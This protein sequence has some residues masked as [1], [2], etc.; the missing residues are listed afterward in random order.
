MARFPRREAEVAALASQIVNGLTEEAEVFTTPPISIEQLQTSLDN[1]RR[2]QEAA[3]IAQASAAEAFDAKDEA[4]ETLKSEMQLVLSYAEHVVGSDPVKLGALGWG[5][6]SEPSAPQPPGPARALE[7]KREG[8][9]WLY[10]DWKKPSEGGPVGGYHVQVAQRETG[11]W[12]QVVMCF[13]TMAVLTDQDTG[14]ELYYR[15]VTF[16]KVGEGFA[17]NVVAAVL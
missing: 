16:N 5:V 2:L 13:D 8:P 6:R 7:I 3:V 11:N 4:F 1:Y 10:L 12:T 9:G 15:V 17:S 14:V